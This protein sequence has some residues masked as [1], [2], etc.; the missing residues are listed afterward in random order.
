ML[1]QAP[2]GGGGLNEYI[3][4]HIHF[5][6]VEVLGRNFHLDSWIMGLFIGAIFF[7]WFYRFARKATPGVPSKGQAFVELIVE[8]VD[9]QVKDLFHGDRSFLAPLGLT[10]FM[11]VLLMNLVDLIPIDLVG[12]V[13]MLVAG[14][15]F[16][17]SFHFKTVATADVYTTFA[18]SLSIF[19]LTMFFSV[20]VKGAGGFLKEQVTSPFKPKG[21]VFGI[22]LAPANI[23][24][25]LVEHLSKPISLSMRLFGNMFG[26]EL[27]FMLVAGLFSSWLSFGF[28]VIFGFAWSVFEL[29][30]IFIQAYIFM[31]LS[32]AYIAMAHEHH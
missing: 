5:N 7:I 26:G 20:K 18:L 21:V 15:D 28:G 27:V 30:I 14:H 8:F 29:L 17:E 31:V 4:H 11:W 1:M 22:I 32:V 16:A 3:Q 12:G 19:V 2:E 25:N 23:I 13:T 24:L 9:G 10:V 6:D